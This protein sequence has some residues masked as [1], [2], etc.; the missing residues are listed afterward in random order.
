MQ[1]EVPPLWY[2][3]QR[4]NAPHLSTSHAWQAAYD[5]ATSKHRLRTMKAA[6]GVQVSWERA[7]RSTQQWRS[8]CSIDQGS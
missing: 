2:S 5:R 8:F 4:R 1:A 3:R 7:D 6:M